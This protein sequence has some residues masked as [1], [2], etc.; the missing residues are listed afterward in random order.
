MSKRSQIFAILVTLS[1]LS[2]AIAA[3]QGPQARW[4]TFQS[5]AGERFYALS[6][7]PTL[8]AEAAATDVVILF[9]TSAS[10]VGLYREDGLAAV[11]SLV[12]SLP[13][14]DQF[15]LYAADLAAVAMDQGFQTAENGK[16]AMEQLKR[17]TPLGST[18]LIRVL[19]TASEAFSDDARR[20]RSIVYIG[21]GMSKANLVMTD[22][23]AALVDDLTSKRIAVTSL[24]IGPDRDVQMLLTL[25]NQTGGMVMIDSDALDPRQAG[26]LPARAARATVAWPVETHMPS[27]IASMYPATFP[28]LRADRDTVVL[29]ELRDQP[30]PAEVAMTVETASGSQQLTWKTTP[31]ASSARVFLSTAIGSVGRDPQGRD[32]AHDGLGRLA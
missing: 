27:V 17:R 24:A 20:A 2:P 6:V 1:M 9:D 10:Q 4:A 8:A 14:G 13:A 5:A 32:V 7:T 12:E 16:P 15:R 3:Q 22:E 26:G 21:D 30:R 29:G 25:A 19:K 28:P 18:D 23:F 11:N 31:E